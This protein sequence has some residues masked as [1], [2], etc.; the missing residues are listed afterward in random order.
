MPKRTTISFIVNTDDNGNKSI[1]KR[2]FVGHV[3]QF[4]SEEAKEESAVSDVNYLFDEIN[5]DKINRH[6][7]V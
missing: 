1:D 7:F 5:S 6:S 4:E 3:E 2:V